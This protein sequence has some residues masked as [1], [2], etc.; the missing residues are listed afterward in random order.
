MRLS[1]VGV[2][3]C[4]A[5]GAVAAQDQQ[6]GARTKGMGGSYTAFEDDPVSIWLNPAGIA[7]QPDQLSV[8]YQTYTAYP[9]TSE[10]GTGD[11]IVTDV[12]P[13]T[14][15]V[16]PPIIPSY[17]G[18]VFQIGD[19]SGPMA[20]GVCYARPYHLNYALNRILDPNQ[21]EFTPK[22][23]VEQAFYRFRAAFARDFKFKDGPGFFTH[24]AVGGGLDVGFSRWEFRSTSET[25]RSDSST[26]FGFGL[27]TLLGLYDNGESFKVAIGLAYQSPI[28]FEFNIDPDVLPAFDM[29]QQINVGVTFYLFK[30]TPLR[31]TLDFQFV[32]WAK[33]AEE[34]IFAGQEEFE[35]AFNFSVGFEYRIRL[36]EKGSMFLY[37]RAGYR[38]F[39]APWGDKD[40][41]PATGA[42]K[43]VLDTKGEAFNL[44]TVGVGFQWTTEAQKVRSIDFG[45]DFGGD[46]FNAAIG[47]TYEL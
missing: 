30:E 22:D 26:S 31:A 23:N 21:T 46:S 36:N 29:P 45:L 47:L 34:P 1:L 38:R 44:F 3:M 14:I 20:I 11:E 37:P 4:L 24:L 7:T 35:D 40:D 42:F 25:D 41:L 27:G 32:S 16:D 43:L 12:E 18:T 17:V 6:L 39:D 13:R 15:L 2:L 19:E 9:V 8:Q 28:E 10:R 33:T 5:A